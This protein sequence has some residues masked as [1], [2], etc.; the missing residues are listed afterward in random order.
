MIM[1]RGTSA[2]AGTAWIATATVLLL[3]GCAEQTQEA[4][5]VAR[6]VETFLVSGSAGAAVTFPGAVE[7]SNKVNL[8]FRIGGPLIELNVDEGDKVRKGQVLARIDPRDFKLAVDATRAAYESTEADFRRFSALYEK[9]GIPATRMDQVRTAREVALATFREAEA[10][11][12][13]T[14]MRAPFD[15]EIGEIFVENFTDVLLKVPILSLVDVSA[16]QVVVDV[17]ESSVITFD[18][19]QLGRIAATFEA[20]PNREYELTLKDIASQADTRTRTYRAELLMTQPEGINVLPGMTVS[21]TAYPLA[22]ADS[23]QRLVV[24]AKAVL[25]EA[26]GQQVVW[27]VD[28][29]TSRVHRRAVSV[30]SI[31]GGDGIEILTGLE[32][33]ERIATTGLNQL[34]EEMEIRLL[35]K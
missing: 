32:G 22:G 7:A 35:E 2:A 12:T 27:V 4:A 33:G 24:P 34:R 17:P 13:D 9:Q 15:G 18:R 31:T 3:T 14:S 6:P 20:V 11:L 23:E 10:K 5:P 19:G 21:V 16:L 8:S 26:D 1:N 30:G 29:A 25:A 28:E